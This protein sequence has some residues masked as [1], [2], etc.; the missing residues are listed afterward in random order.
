[1]ASMYTLEELI[2]SEA[3]TNL[4][5]ISIKDEP[6]ILIDSITSLAE[7]NGGTIILGVT[8]SGVVE[9]ITSPHQF[10]E[11]CI[12]LLNSH[13]ANIE[14]AFEVLSCMDQEDKNNEVLLLHVF[15]YRE[16]SAFYMINDSLQK[17]TLNLLMKWLHQKEDLKYC[18]ERYMI[19]IHQLD[20]LTD[21]SSSER[22]ILEQIIMNNRVTQDQLCEILD[23][24]KS[25]IRRRMEHLKARD[26]LKRV[27]SSIKGYWLVKLE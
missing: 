6:G 24:S 7:N 15:P 22:S 23:E 5:K 13:Q 2:N 4:L 27:G 1:M 20:R 18:D 3:R 9:G 14:I 25:S 19:R 11:E 16:K 21:I 26:I 8:Q 17:T 12:Q 10:A